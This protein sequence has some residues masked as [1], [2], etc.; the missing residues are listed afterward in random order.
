LKYL[1]YFV[2]A[3]PCIAFANDHNFDEH[4]FRS[5]YHEY[6][7]GDKA[8]DI[9]FTKD[10]NITSWRI[11]HLPA[12]KSGTFWSYMDGTYVLLRNSDHKIID[13]K[14]SDIFYRHMKD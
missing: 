7:I 5:N 4:T 6:S 1:M 14:S 9:N 11:R 13:A 8:P 10:Y 2:I 12:P 3:L